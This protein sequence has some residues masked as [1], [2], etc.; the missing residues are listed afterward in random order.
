MQ[1]PAS[2]PESIWIRTTRQFHRAAYA[3]IQFTVTVS[4]AIKS[5][6]H[7]NILSHPAAKWIAG[8]FGWALIGGGIT[9][10]Q[11]D[12]YAPALILFVSGS[13]VLFLKAFHWKGIYSWPKIG[14]AL[15]FVFM[16]GALIMVVS[17]YQITIAKK[18]NKPWSSFAAARWLQIPPTPS[19]TA[20]AYPPKLDMFPSTQIAVPSEPPK[21]PS[22][23]LVANGSTIPALEFRF[24]GR[25]PYTVKGPQYTWFRF[26][27]YNSG[28]RAIGNVMVKIVHIRPRPRDPEFR[29]SFPIQLYNSNSI[30]AVLLNPR[31]EELFIVATT[32]ISSVGRIMVDLN[33]ASSGFGSFAFSISEDERWDLIL[34]ISSAMTTPREIVLIMSVKDGKAIIKRP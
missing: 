20:P 5:F 17:S 21:Q 16:L 33:R 30:G 29:I 26:G 14:K 8:Q 10:A 24:S 23:P 18:G 31:D 7:S 3:T 4:R 19:T 27:V 34:H 25:T 22:A 9:L 12:E 11:W 15:R 2:P 13:V 32:W 28:S 1:V 6:I